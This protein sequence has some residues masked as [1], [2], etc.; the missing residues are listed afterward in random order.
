[1]SIS[2]SVDA[3]LKQHLSLLYGDLAAQVFAKIEQLIAT[4]QPIITKHGAVDKGE[5]LWDE[6]TI[7]LITYGDQIRD[8]G[9]PSLRSLRN[10]LVEHQLDRSINTVHLLPIF[11]YSSDDGFSVIDYRAIRKSLGDW[12]D[13]KHLGQKF[14][15]ALDFVLNHCSRESSWF[16]GYLNGE[17]PFA[18]FF[19]EVDPDIDLS[20]VTRPRT[21]PLLTSVQTNRGE[22]HVWSTFSSD[23]MDLNFA[24][25][26][27]LMEMLD[28]LLLYVANGAKIIRLDA[29]GFLWK[30]IGT[31]CMHLPQTHEVVKLM[32]T[33]L[34][35]IAPD[36]ILLTETNVPHQE[37][38][39]YFG[40][41]DEARAVYQFSL[42]PLLLDAYLR[43][44]ASLLQQWLEDLEYPETG[45]TFFNFTASH[46]GIGVRPLEGI[47][48]PE[49]IDALA[50]RVLE[51]G[52]KV[53]WRE[54]PD[55][56]QS[57]YELNITYFSALAETDDDSGELHVR[58]FLASQA[59]MLSLR[60]I[61]GV[62]FHSLI[63]SEN[64]LE[65]VLQTGENRSINRQKFSS[66]QLRERLAGNNPKPRIV[67][68]GYQKL[69]SLRCRQKAFHPEAAQKML[70][71]SDSRLIAFERTSCDGEQKVIVLANFSN[72]Q[73]VLPLPS[74]PSERFDLLSGDRIHGSTCTLNAYQVVWLV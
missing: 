27:L 34:D 46:D 5:P 44:D 49:R 64:D 16:A 24:S 72:Q 56:S 2:A 7:V 41:G 67:F 30:E 54:K 25:P 42:A 9:V 14:D 11:P 36:T 18:D 45:M 35:A 31:T 38:I 10:F 17:Q 57:P 55:G 37:N 48:P 3:K 13:V 59:I 63:G 29:I 6:S 69:L 60:G 32:R 70:S 61:P 19:I 15:L 53:N 65:G 73:I 23:Q 74:A 50:N 58:K 43:K 68:E 21:S 12:Q 39:S 26:S 51:L 71:I 52:G 47:V 33:I 40:R 1:M 20:D 28:I 8:E 66:S 4:Y 62:Y 22:R